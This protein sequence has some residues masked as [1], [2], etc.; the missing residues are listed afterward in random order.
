[1]IALI[2]YHLHLYLKSGRFFLPFLLW[3]F[4]LL[5][6]FSDK[7]ASLSGNMLILL[8]VLYVCMAMVG[9][10]YMNAEQNETAADQVMIFHTKSMLR[11]NLSK[12]LFLDLVSFIMSMY[13]VG[14]AILWYLLRMGTAKDGMFFRDWLAFLAALWLFASVGAM[15]GALLHPRLIW[16]KALSL[17]ALM[18]TVLLTFIKLSVID[19]AGSVQVFLRWLLPPNSEILQYF[20]GGNAGRNIGM[21]LLWLAV[22][23]MILPVIQCILLERKRY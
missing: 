4:T 10:F 6:V 21:L 5:F 2:K 12:N 1:M 17:C 23:S 8:S 18:G 9:Y 20:G 11:Y 19:K 7:N 14:A 15:Q 3:T 13:G 16:N 22:Y